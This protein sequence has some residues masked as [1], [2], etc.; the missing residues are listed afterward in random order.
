MLLSKSIVVTFI[1]LDEGF[2]SLAHQL[3]RSNTLQKGLYS[4]FVFF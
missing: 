4:S 2:L 1:S 3:L